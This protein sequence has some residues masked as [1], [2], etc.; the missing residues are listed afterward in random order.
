MAME[1][2]VDPKLTG[3]AEVI[4]ITHLDARGQLQPSDIVSL[5]GMTSG[6]VTNLLD[7]LEKNGFIR[8]EY[9]TMKGDRRV[10]V[11][12]LTP[13]GRQLARDYARAVLDLIDE[14]RVVGAR[15]TDVADPPED[16]SEELNVR[17]REPEAG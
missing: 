5:T 16:S 12:S 17:D 14:V 13:L 8:R 2:R 4:V 6:G 7:R 9:G 11:L 3:N 10:S 1:Q 15:L